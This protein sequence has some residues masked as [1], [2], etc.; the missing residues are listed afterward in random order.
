MALDEA[1]LNV[2]T[3][4]VGYVLSGSSEDEVSITDEELELARRVAIRVLEQ[5]DEFESEPEEEEVLK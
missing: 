2:A 5:L 1:R 3:N 4:A